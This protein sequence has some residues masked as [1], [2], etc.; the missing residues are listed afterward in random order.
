MKAYG[1]FLKS[2]NNNDLGLPQTIGPSRR[3]AI[4]NWLW[5]FEN[6]R[7]LAGFDD[8]LIDKLWLN[9]KYQDARIVE[10]EITITGSIP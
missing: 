6:T 4:V 7:I 5:T 10:V 1:V 9:R 2:G 3:S 8:D